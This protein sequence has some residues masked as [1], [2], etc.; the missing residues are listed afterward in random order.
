MMRKDDYR[1]VATAPLRT[2]GWFAEAANAYQRDVIPAINMNFGVAAALKKWQEAY[3]DCK[4]AAPIFGKLGVSGPALT[5]A[6]LEKMGFNWD[7]PVG[8][9]DYLHVMNTFQSAIWG[10]YNSLTGKWK[11]LFKTNVNEYLGGKNFVTDF[12][13]N[14][15]LIVQVMCNIKEAAGSA[16]GAPGWREFELLCEYGAQFLSLCAMDLSAVNEMGEQQYKM[17]LL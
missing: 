13:A 15:A 7:D 11:E 14:N 4:H 8:V 6:V 3:P 1:H 10:Y 17:S 12:S 2:W 5:R 9:P 16:A